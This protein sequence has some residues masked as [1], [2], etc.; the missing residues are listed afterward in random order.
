MKSYITK[1]IQKWLLVVRRLI[2]PAWGD[3]AK[4]RMIAERLETTLCVNG[5]ITLNFGK[6]ELHDIYEE[7]F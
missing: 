1:N 2:S 5:R 3:F 6:K 4:E 7:G